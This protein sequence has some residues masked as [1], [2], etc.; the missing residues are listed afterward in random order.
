M[1]EAPDR[2]A[3]LLGAKLGALVRSRWP[4][5][6][7]AARPGTFPGGASLIGPEGGSAWILLDDEADA[8]RRLG[9]TLAV[10]DRAGT[11]EL[12][13]LIDDP[14]AAG[15]VARRASQFARPP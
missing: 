13:L 11:S 5:E 10:A 9:A 6:A 14:V 4:E 1:T 15:I 8:A 2:R 7:D 3:A 12:H